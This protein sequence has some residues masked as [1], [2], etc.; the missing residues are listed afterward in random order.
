MGSNLIGDSEFFPSLFM[1]VSTIPLKHKTTHIHRPLPYLT[2][3]T[4][5][6]EVDKRQVYKHWLG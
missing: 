1:C 3:F 5:N 4:Q 6:F 2:L